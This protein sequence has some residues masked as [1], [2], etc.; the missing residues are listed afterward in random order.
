MQIVPQRRVGDPVIGRLDHGLGQRQV[1]GRE[2]GRH[3]RDRKKD[4]GR[5][6]QQ[7]APPE[8]RFSQV[9][10]HGRTAAHAKHEHASI[11][12]DDVLDAF[13]PVGYAGRLVRIG[14]IRH[15]AKVGKISPT[16]AVCIEK[17]RQTPKNHPDV[18]AAFANF[19]R[20]TQSFRR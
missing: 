12:P 15:A 10:R 11:G 17:Y 3:L 5:E 14:R 8:N 7:V 2:T 9:R 4:V 16:A 1:A 19:A 20:S 18:R 13:A 6:H